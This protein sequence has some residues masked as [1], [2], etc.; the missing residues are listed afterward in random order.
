MQALEI[1]DLVVNYGNVSAVRGVNIKVDAGAIVCVLGANGA[2]KSSLLRSIV[3]LAP[4]RSGQI[5]YAGQDIARLP[6]HQVVDRQIMLSPE[7]RRL[8][9]ELTVL[10][11]LRVGAF[12]IRSRQEVAERLEWV[13]GFFPRLRER[14]KQVAGSMSGGEQQ[15]CAIARALMSKPKLLLLDEPSLGLAPKVIAEVARI[16]R[17]IQAAGITVMLVEQNARLALSLSSYGYVMV[18]GAISLEGSSKDLLDSAHVRA[19]Y[20]GEESI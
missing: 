18:S 8:F 2:G 10:D 1:K 7:G 6:P 15:M 11:N 16:I 17:E 13:Y 12:K 5:L 19:A 3:G 14:E 9:P 4:V 20:L